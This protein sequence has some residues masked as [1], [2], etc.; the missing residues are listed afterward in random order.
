VE[1]LVT[2]IPALFLLLIGWTVWRRRRRSPAAPAEV[3][4]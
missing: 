2:A 4:A 3:T 1:I